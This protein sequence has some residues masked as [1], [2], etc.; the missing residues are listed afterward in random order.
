MVCALALS[1][2]GKTLFS[3]S[4]DKTIR[5]WSIETGAV[6]TRLAA[7]G[8]VWTRSARAWDRLGAGARADGGEREADSAGRGA[9]SAGATGS[10]VHVLEA[11]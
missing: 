5:A 6:R 9:G 8:A 10:G 1:S 2:D 7:A 11:G 3:G 4:G